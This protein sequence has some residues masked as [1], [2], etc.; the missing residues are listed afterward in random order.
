[1]AVKEML[2]SS[3]NDQRNAKGILDGF[4]VV[5]VWRAR[6]SLPHSIEATVSLIQVMVAVEDASSI[7]FYSLGHAGG[8]SACHQGRRWI[9]V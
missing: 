7:S 6:G 1:M 3:Y 2:Y 5:D 9:C 8:S 4:S